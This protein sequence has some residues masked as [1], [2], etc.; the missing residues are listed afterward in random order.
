MYNLI[1]LF[2]LLSL[3]A[4]CLAR[5]FDFFFFVQQ[6]PASYCDSRKGCCYPKTGKPAEDFSIHGLWPNYEDGTYPSNCDSSNSFDKSEHRRELAGRSAKSGGADLRPDKQNAKGLAY[7]CLPSGDGY[8]FWGHE[9]E[10]HGTCSESVLDQHGYF[11]TALGLKNKSNLLSTLQSAGI[12]PANGRYHTLN[13]IKE[14]IE[15]ALGVTPYIECNV[16]PAGN[17]QLYQVYLCVDSSASDFM[18]C[19]VMPHGR[20]CG[21][22]IEFPSFSDLTDDERDEL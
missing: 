11:Q 19:P 22:K 12:W 16:D 17:H 13:S 8:K 1:N 6:W 14:A 5:D 10:K 15:G 9:W 2:L 20:P 7:P 3:A 18:E 21:S 4:L